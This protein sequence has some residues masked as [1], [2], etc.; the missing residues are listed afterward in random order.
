MK[1]NNFIPRFTLAQSFIEQGLIH[2]PVFVEAAEVQETLIEETGSYRLLG[3]I[4]AD[5]EETS[6]T[7]TKLSLRDL[8]V[9][10]G[11]LK[12]SSPTIRTNLLDLTSLTDQ[13]DLLDLS[14]LIEHARQLR[15]TC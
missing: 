10:T 6:S 2:N 15:K 1:Y 11:A 12:N 4:L 9:H 7:D 5:M 8:L 14:E 3:S 13:N